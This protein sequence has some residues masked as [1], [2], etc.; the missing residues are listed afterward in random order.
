MQI[1]K[2]FRFTKL[3][4]LKNSNSVPDE[5]INYF[6]WLQ[7]EQDQLIALNQ[8]LELKPFA[9]Q[10]VVSNQMVRLTIEI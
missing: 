9:M 5:N 10:A 4:T 2:S 7:L 1:L 6:L 8:L 3:K